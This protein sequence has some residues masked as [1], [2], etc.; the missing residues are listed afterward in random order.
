[1]GFVTADVGMKPSCALKV[2]LEF[3]RTRCFGALLSEFPIDR[4]FCM[5]IVPKCSTSLTFS[6]SRGS[7]VSVM[8]SM[9]LY[10]SFAFSDRDPLVRLDVANGLDTSLLPTDR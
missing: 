9:M 6:A 2:S 5:Q 10:D 7:H 8:E 1:M 3:L 4:P